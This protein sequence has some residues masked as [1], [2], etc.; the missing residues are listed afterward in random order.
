MNG[1]LPQVDQREGVAVAYAKGTSH[2][3]YEDAFRMLSRD[4]PLVA[5]R[6]RGEVF[7]VFD[8]IGSAPEGRHS[9][10]VMADALV[11][12]YREPERYPVFEVG[13]I[14]I[15][16]TANMKISSWGVVEGSNRSIGGCAGTVVWLLGE[17]LHLFHAGD[18]SAVLIRDG[19]VKALTREHQAE[20]GAIVRF[21]GIGQNFKMDVNKVNVE[22]GDRILLVSDGVTKCCT[23][24]EAGDIV[25][26]NPLIQ[27][28]V[29][30]LVY[31]C[32]LAGV[33]DD[34]TAMLI[35]VE[36]FWID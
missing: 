31:Q 12:F 28:A 23:A 10:Q 14:K 9:A 6:N 11:R 18:T 1:E 35:E 8:G 19:L 3:F 7:A 2:R 16:V 27:N 29:R 30:D 17:E 25:G 20:D 4:I 22:E 21:F 15:L 5:Q 34:I 32:K 24:L 33:N 13:L 36:E 26:D